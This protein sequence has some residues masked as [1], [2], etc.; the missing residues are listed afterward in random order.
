MFMCWLWSIHSG[1]TTSRY[2]SSGASTSDI[3]GDDL[4][5]EAPRVDPKLRDRHGEPK[6]PRS[7][8]ARI[9][10]E[11]AVAP[12]DAR[13]VGMAGDDRVEAGGARVEVELVKV[14][15]H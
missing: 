13:L 3:E 9:Q 11:H 1:R 5:R 7:G 12:L 15:Q 8:A 2:R 14:V 4:G 10:I 6:T